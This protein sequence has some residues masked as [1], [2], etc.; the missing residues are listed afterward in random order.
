MPGGYGSI[1]PYTKCPAI[2]KCPA[3]KSWIEIGGQRHPRVRSV[4]MNCY[5]NGG[6]GVLAYSYGW[7]VYQ[8]MAEIVNP[9]PSQA[10]VFLD[11]HEDSITIGYFAVGAGTIWPDT[12]WL[13]LPASRHRGVCTLSFADGHAEIKKWRDART[14]VPVK[15]V[16]FLGAFQ[17]PQNKDVLWMTERASSSKNPDAPPQT[18]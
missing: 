11:E 5:M 13:Q 9:S 3:D 4:S 18:P 7:Y 17:Q 16:L 8:K 2:Y 6:A 15:R 14:L 10:F 12:R 1:G